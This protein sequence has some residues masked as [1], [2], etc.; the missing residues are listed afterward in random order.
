MRV[1]VTGANGF[2]GR[3]VVAQAV[4]AGHDVTALVRPRT[5]ANPHPFDPSVAVVHGDLR[6]GG[7][8]TSSLDAIDVVVHAAAAAGGDRAQ[9]LSNTVVATERLLGHLSAALPHRFVH[10]SSFSVYDFHALSNGACLD[11]GSPLE[12]C[13]RE[14]DAYTEAKLVQEQLVRTWCVERDVPCVILRPGAIVGPE[15]PW[16]YGAAV[17]IG[18]FAFVIAPNARFRLIS[19][20]NCAAAIVKAVEVGSDGIDTINL[21]DDELPT[22]AQYF[23]RC[24]KVGAPDRIMVP[25]PWRLVDAV[26]R[27]LRT[28]SVRFLGGRLRTPELL[29]HRRQEARWKPL[30]YANDRAHRVLGWQSEQTL[31]ETVRLAVGAGGSVPRG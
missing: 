22:H 2:L 29:D 23:R 13:P 27:V 30:S 18:R 15:K 21:V 7:R 4:A 24:R 12:P 28:V 11:E 10:V 26:G 8:W 9:Q 20:A 3:E 14:R 31:E 1:L 6:S 19:L 17:G 5:E 16:G 25:V